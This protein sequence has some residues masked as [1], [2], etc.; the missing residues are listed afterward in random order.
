MSYLS[1]IKLLKG[2]KCILVVISP[3]TDSEAQFLP[4]V[5]VM[6]KLVLPTM[7]TSLTTDGAE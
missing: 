7:E 6:S 2:Q 1:V 4:C 3:T 5:A